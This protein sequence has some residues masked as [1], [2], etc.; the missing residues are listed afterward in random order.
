[1]LFASSD[2][3]RRIESAECDL[4]TASVG[5]VTDAAPDADVVTLR[6]GGGVAIYAGP[7][8]PLTKVAGIGFDGPLDEADLDRVE[9]L[10][11]ARGVPVQV[12]L[13]SLADPSVAPMMTGRGY[14]LVAFENVLGAPLST[15]TATPAAGSEAIEIGPSGDD[16]FDV[17]LDTL[18]DGFG[19]P[20]EHGVPAHQEFSRDAIRAVMRQM[21][22]A[23][24]MVRYLARR[25]GDP[26][27]GGSMRIGTDVAH[28]CG[29]ATLPAHRRKGVQRALLRHR[30]VAAAA[31]GCEVAV[32]TTM[33][34]STSQKNV[35]ASGFELLYTRAILV[36][37][38]PTTLPAG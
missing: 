29:A 22:R 16:D 5:A 30:L 2:L 23:E 27:G 13:S 19:T 4:L 3:A 6:V 34:G 37:P 20:D 32:V 24:G 33:P 9:A 17:W 26:A 7:E 12:E 8:S 38:V 36:R 1:M 11:D 25:N 15:T 18:V 35:Q 31:A 21:A 10:F 14:D 28:M